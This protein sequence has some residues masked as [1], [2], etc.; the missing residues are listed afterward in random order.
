MNEKWLNKELIGPVTAQDVVISSA[1]LVAIIIIA[2]AICSFISWRKRHA[3][4]A[5]AR[6]ASNFTAR[7]SMRLR[8]SIMG[9][10][11]VEPSEIVV[12]SSGN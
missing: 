6:R 8:K 12:K 4:A 9:K 11:D 5:G 3:I 2:V 1:A 10:R 7:K